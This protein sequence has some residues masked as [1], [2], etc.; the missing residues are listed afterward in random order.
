M[1]DDPQTKIPAGERREHFRGRST[2]G[3]RVDLSYRRA[4]GNQTLTGEN[5][6]HVVA[7]NL[8]VGGAYLLSQTPEPVGSLL[9]IHLH[10]PGEEDALRIE[11]EVAW[12]KDGKLG[13][14][15]MGVQF[16][17]LDTAALLALG[18]YFAKLR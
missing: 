8:G 14:A 2:P 5:E 4:D 18:N 7:I 6:S 10:I 11:G 15:G 3:N 17:Q 12:T 16:A 9:K 1:S 13:D